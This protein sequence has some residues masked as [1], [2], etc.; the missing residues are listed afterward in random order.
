MNMQIENALIQ[1]VVAVTPVFNRREITLACLRSLFASNLD[2]VDLQAIVVDDGSSDGTADAIRAEF[3][4]VEIITGDGN[5]WYSE[6]VNVGVRSALS[7]DPDFILIYN[8]DSLF[9]PATLRQLLDTAL[10]YPTSIV[11]A[12]LV[13][14]DNKR[15]VFQTGIYWQTSYGGWHPRAGQTIDDLPDGPFP[16]ETLAGNCILLPAE[17]FRDAGLM[18]SD[19]LPNFGDAELMARMRRRGWRVLIDPKAQLLCMPNDVPAPLSSMSAAEV[20]DA[21]WRRRTSYHN[22][23][24]RRAATMGGAPGPIQGYAAHAIFLVRFALRAMGFRTH[25][26]VTDPSRPLRETEMPMRSSALLQSGKGHPIVFAWLYDHWGGVQVYMINLMKAASN[27]GFRVIVAVPES[28]APDHLALLR[29]ASDEIH[30][31]KHVQDVG[32]APTLNRK[33]ARRINNFRAEKEFM[34]L[35]EANFPA[36]ALVHIDTAPWAAPKML[37]RL[38]KHFAVVVTVHTGLPIVGRIRTWFWRR[39]F[40]KVATL[41]KFRLIAANGEA[42]R[43][44]SRYVELDYLDRVPVSISSF[45]GKAIEAALAAKPMRADYETKL[46]LPSAPF[47]IV[48]GAQLIERKGYAVLIEALRTLRG[49]GCDIAALWIA[50]SPPAPHDAAIMDRAV[51]EGLIEFRLGSDIGPAHE[52]YLM[53]LSALADAFVLPSFVEGLPLAL[54]EAM[55]LEICSL[56]TR[57]NSIPDLIHDGRTGLLVQAGDVPGL[58]AAL[59]R[60]HDDHSLRQSLARQGRQFVLERFELKVATEQTLAVYDDLSAL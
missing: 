49:Q 53:A 27:A 5:L 36:G 35:A 12:T 37:S 11:G 13:E 56:S 55:A 58:A 33:I 19:K 60:I 6:G 28:T 18:K 48:A 1:R 54:V 16:A 52:D 47:R 30:F 15:V 41:D 4:Q 26:P 38:A 7:S 59:R 8:D 39:S 45:D 43:S 17:A 34:A 9:P 44:L 20:V 2:G 40:S 22:L 32:D 51:A 25:W 14:W 21:L 57:I 31:L 10:N 50:P 23:R 42:R 24:Q 29:G 46:G 3:P